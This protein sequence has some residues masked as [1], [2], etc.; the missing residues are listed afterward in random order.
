MVVHTVIAFARQIIVSWG[1]N[2]GTRARIGPEP[3]QRRGGD[4]TSAVALTSPR[5]SV[6][7][8]AGVGPTDGVAARWRSQGHRGMMDRPTRWRRNMSPSDELAWISANELAR[9]IRAR[10]LSPVEVVDAAIA[11]IEAR[12]PSLNALVYTG[13]DEARAQ[14]RAAEDALMS[15]AELGPLHGVPDRRSRTCST[16]SR[17]GRSTF[18]GI[19]ALQ[20]LHGPTILRLRRAD[21]GGRRDPHRQDQQPDDGLPRH[22]PTTSCS[23][24]RATRSTLAQERRRLLGRQR[25]RPSPTG[26]CR[27]PKAPT[28]AARSASRRPGAAST[29]TRPRS[30]AI[31]FVARGPTPSAAPRR[32]SSRADHPHRR[33]RGA[34]ADRARRLRPARPVQPRRARSTSCGADP[35]DRAAGRSP[36][37]RPRRLPGRAGRRR[38]SSRRPC[39]RSRRR[40]RR[41]RRSS[42]ASSAPSASSPTS[43]AG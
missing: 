8:S 41:S 6:A 17:A 40:A 24:R 28:A 31:P 35:L 7:A 19:R 16:S 37:A 12:N 22:V 3:A 39:G 4:R 42:S 14:A 27:S 13:F 34:G 23:A 26:C 10:E 29:A 21:R 43:G 33:G 15:G 9:R 5:R 18:G 11:R 1:P 30:A 32:S 2:R 25:R 36:T 20:G 38:R